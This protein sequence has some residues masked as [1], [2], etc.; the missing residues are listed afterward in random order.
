MGGQAVVET[1]SA[2]PA[3]VAITS[4]RRA[5]PGGLDDGSSYT[6]RSTAPAAAP[7]PTWQEIV[8]HLSR[9]LVGWSFDDVL[10][11]CRRPHIHAP[12][13]EPFAAGELVRVGDR[14]PIH[15]NPGSVE[16]WHIPV[17]INLAKLLL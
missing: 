8:V 5:S 7:E 14:G 12:I 13:E 10:R 9:T 4:P 1:I 15:R 16:A 2:R 11:P 17:F 3:G 6:L